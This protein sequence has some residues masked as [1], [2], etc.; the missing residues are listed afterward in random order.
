[1]SPDAL[2]RWLTV[3]FVTGRYAPY[4]DAIRSIVWSLTLGSILYWAALAIGRPL[5][6]IDTLIIGGLVPVVIGP[7]PVHG[8][9]GVRI[10]ERISIPG[11]IWYL[12]GC[13]PG[14]LALL[15]EALAP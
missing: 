9:F 13:L 8:Y 6:L 5:A 3:E 10:A 15:R 4:H 11:A 1:M 14:D 7:N 2:L 12:L